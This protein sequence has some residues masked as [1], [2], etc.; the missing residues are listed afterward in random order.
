MSLTES[1]VLERE[2]LFLSSWTGRYSAIDL[3]CHTVS[4]HY[5]SEYTDKP[6][7]PRQA[8]SFLMR[9]KMK[10][11]FILQLLFLQKWKNFDIIALYRRASQSICR[12]GELLAIHLS[13]GHSSHW[14]TWKSGKQTYWAEISHH[15][16]YEA[17]TDLSTATKEVLGREP[18]R[19]FFSALRFKLVENFEAKPI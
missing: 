10:L 17:L 18:H 4:V 1:A 2:L 13:A 3:N 16:W 9:K 15:I 6:R 12:C 5:E 14:C 7:Q 11:I 19:F 8:L